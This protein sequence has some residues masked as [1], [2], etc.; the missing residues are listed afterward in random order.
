M[1]EYLLYSLLPVP[2][3]TAIIMA[4]VICLCTSRFRKQGRVLAT[5]GALLLLFFS[6]PFFSNMALGPIEHRYGQLKLDEV[7][8]RG[9]NDVGFIVVLA[10]GHVQDPDIPPESRFNYA[11]LVRLVEGVRLYYKLGKAKLVLSGGPGICSSTDAD[12][13]AVVAR[14][15]GVKSDD[16]I[17]ERESLTT[18]DEARLLKP[19]LKN[20]RFILVTSASHMPRAMKIF[21]QLG[22]NPF[23]APTGYLVKHCCKASMGIPGGSSIDKWETVFYETAATVKY[24][25]HRKLN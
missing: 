10:A 1:I 17:L 8:I 7:S 22:M 21:T 14:E 5:L 13:M 6:L 19:L 2:L 25:I 15:L 24:Y 11:G 4:G 3:C 12:L 18:L 20:G 9:L 23:A 16:I